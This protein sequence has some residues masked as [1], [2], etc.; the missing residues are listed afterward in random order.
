MP[1]N[2][3]VEISSLVPPLDPEAQDAII[4]YRYRCQ[5]PAAV[6]NPPPSYF[7]SEIGGFVRVTGRLS[8]PQGQT[9]PN[10]ADCVFYIR[11]YSLIK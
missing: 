11:M 3:V 4:P 9:P 1:S 6:R 2:V 10:S 7:K 8:Y 5:I